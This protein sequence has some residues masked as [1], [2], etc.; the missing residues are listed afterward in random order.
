M[1]EAEIDV[2]KLRFATRDTTGSSSFFHQPAKI[3]LLEGAELARIA[4]GDPKPPWMFSPLLL[5][6]CEA[7]VRLSWPVYRSDRRAAFVICVVSIEW[8]GAVINYKV[9]K[10]FRT[11][12]WQQGARGG[13]RNFTDWRDGRCY[14]DEWP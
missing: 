10:D 13:R 4:E 8:W 5:P 9:D 2:H 1:P 3:E 14:I 11:G 7:V 6:N 12:K